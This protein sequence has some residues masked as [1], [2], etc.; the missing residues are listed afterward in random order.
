MKAYVI[1]IYAQQILQYSIITVAAAEIKLVEAWKSLKHNDYPFQL[2]QNNPT[3]IHCEREMRSTTVKL[4][5]DEART[6]AASESIS[7]DCAK[8]WNNAP[9]TI[10]NAPTLSCA[11]K[12]IKIY[13]R[14]FE[15]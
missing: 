2:E 6:R 5:K 14:S 8:L 7:R 4:W 9:T 3:K 12:E 13:C 11:K 15:L 1:D 10:K